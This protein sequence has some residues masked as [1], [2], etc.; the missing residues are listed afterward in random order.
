MVLVIAP[1]TDEAIKAGVKSAGGASA[2]VRQYSSI[3][4]ELSEAGLIKYN[5]S[6]TNLSIFEGTKE[7]QLTNIGPYKNIKTG[8]I[9]TA[10]HDKAT[11]MLSNVNA[12]GIVNRFDPDDYVEYSETTQRG[13]RDKLVELKEEITGEKANEVK[14]LVD[15]RDLRSQ[16]S[17]GLQ[18]LMSKLSSDYKTLFGRD[19]S[20][21]EYIDRRASSEFEALLGTVR[22]EVLGPGVLTEQDALRL[23]TAMGGFGATSNRDVAVGLLDELISRKQTIINS[24]INSYNYYRKQFAE[25]GREFPEMNL[26]TALEATKPVGDDSGLTPRQEAVMNSLRNP[27]GTP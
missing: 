12:D 5:D 19:L 10:G 22:L 25:V 20:A 7:V 23:M 16:T 15:F 21:Q 17:E 1:L 4:N 11:G 14:Q 2:F 27:T 26:L 13:V 9:I 24:K 3:V 18:L 6:L 8:E